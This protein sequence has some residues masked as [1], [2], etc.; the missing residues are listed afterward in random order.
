MFTVNGTMLPDPTVL[1]LKV[2]EETLCVPPACPLKVSAVGETLRTGFVVTTN[3]TGIAVVL[4]PETVIIKV[5][6]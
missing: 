1:T 3:I 6:V 4:P 2:C 5:V